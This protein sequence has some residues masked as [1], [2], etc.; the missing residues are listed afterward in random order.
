LR[1]DDGLEI[2]VY[3][4]GVRVFAYVGGRKRVF[5]SKKEAKKLL[6]LG[7]PGDSGV[8][9]ASYGNFGDQ[10]AWMAGSSPVMTRKEREL[11]H[12]WRHNSPFVK[13]FCFFFQKKA[14]TCL[15]T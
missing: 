13:V 11:W 15:M 7:A 1:E 9:A 4:R 2:R 3:A 5:F 12:F 8:A 14:L 10:K 6:L